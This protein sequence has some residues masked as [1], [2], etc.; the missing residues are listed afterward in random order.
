MAKS[1]VYRILSTLVHNGF[2]IKDSTTNKYRLSARLLYFGHA[3]LSQYPFHRHAQPILHKLAH[4]TK[5]AAHLYVLHGTEIVCIGKV[6]GKH[7]DPS[8]AYIGWKGPAHLT[9]GQAILAYSPSP[10]FP[11]TLLPKLAKVKEQGMAISRGEDREGLMAIAAPVWNKRD[12]TVCAAIDIS[13]AV[14][15]FAPD[16]ISLYSE[17]VKQAAKE[18]SEAISSVKENRDSLWEVGNQE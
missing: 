11:P 10:A 5:E 14:Q 13:G 15:R 4:Q 18:L 2:V 6:E 7:P 12:N 1:T 8:A 16:K 17:F 9:A 3:V